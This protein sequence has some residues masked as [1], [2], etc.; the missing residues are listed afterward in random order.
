MFFGIMNPKPS[1]K[2][3]SASYK[4]DIIICAYRRTVLKILKSVNYETSARFNSFFK[5]CVWLNLRSRAED[6]NS[7]NILNSELGHF[8]AIIEAPGRVI[9]PSSKYGYLMSQRCPY[10]RVIRSTKCGSNIFRLIELCKIQNF[11]NYRPVLCFPNVAPK[12]PVK[13]F[14]SIRKHWFRT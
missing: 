11:Q 5:T 9:W 6:T 14:Q 10:L 1:R 12:V 13:H 2:D 3:R 7:A 4:Y 8:I